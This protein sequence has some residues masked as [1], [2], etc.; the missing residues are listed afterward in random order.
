MNSGPCADV[1]VLSNEDGDRAELYTSEIRKARKEHCCCECR[2]PIAP[3]Q[4]YEHVFMIL[5]GDRQT[6]KTCDL[7]VEIRGH[8]SCDGGWFFE[9]VWEELREHLFDHMTLGC[10]GE[11]G[12]KP[13]LSSAAKAKV[14]AQWRKWKGLE[15]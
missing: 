1:C 15:G 8:F 7:C 11:I 14:I 13:G 5:D 2:Q 10:L 3:G 4:T 6:Y 9:T 12:E